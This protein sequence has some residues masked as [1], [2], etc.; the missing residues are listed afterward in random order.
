LAKLTMRA[1]RLAPALATALAL[2]AHATGAGAEPERRA[3]QLSL[4]AGPALGICSAPCSDVGAGFDFGGGAGFRLSRR[5]MTGA[6]FDRSYVHWSPALASSQ[7]LVMTQGALGLRYYPFELGAFEPWVELAAGGTSWDATGPHSPGPRGGITVTPALGL[8]LFVTPTVEVGG[9]A[10]FGLV[11]P[12][13]TG[14]ADPLDD[15]GPHIP[16]VDRILRFDAAI[17]FLLGPKI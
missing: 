17:T 16:T 9:R 3:I 10:A 7:Y 5:F 6:W 1:L 13:G 15:A 4:F 11:F 8:D 12:T 2:A 14:Y